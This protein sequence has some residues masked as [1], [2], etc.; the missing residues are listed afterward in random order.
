MQ[1][2]DMDES[3]RPRVD[4]AGFGTRFIA[5]LI[6]GV[7]I[8]LLGWLM[9]IF[10][11]VNAFEASWG[12]IWFNNILSLLYFIVMEG[13]SKNATIG[14][15]LVGIRVTDMQGAPIGY[16]KAALRNICKILSALILLIGFIMIAFTERKQGLHDSIANT[17]VVR[18]TP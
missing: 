6:D 8:S 13:G 3:P 15:Q 5:W 16:D 18:N 7:I 10:L 12:V 4:Y 2:L 17:L 14:K 11:G 9:G 1:I